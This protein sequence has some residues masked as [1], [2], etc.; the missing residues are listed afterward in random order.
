MGC[1][2]EP[3]EEDQGGD[4]DETENLVAAVEAKLFGSAG[5]LGLLFLVRCDAEIG[6]GN[7]DPV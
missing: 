6:H 4:Q 5:G 2:D 1:A 7:C 3:P